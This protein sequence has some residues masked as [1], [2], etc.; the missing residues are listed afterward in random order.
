[1]F[2]R[3]FASPS[4]EVGVSKLLFEKGVAREFS[5]KMLQQILER[6]QRI[7]HECFCPVEKDSSTSRAEDVGRTQI[8]VADSVE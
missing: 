1:M 6:K 2:R 4:L 3:N 5:T 7:T 8:H